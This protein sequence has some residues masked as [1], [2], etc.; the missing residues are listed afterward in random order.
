MKLKNKCDVFFCQDVAV[1]FER[2][3]A[4]QLDGEVISGVTRYRAWK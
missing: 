1:E 3:C 2:P 4:I